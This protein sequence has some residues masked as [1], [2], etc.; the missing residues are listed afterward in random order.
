MTEP[1]RDRQPV[2][3]PWCGSE[4]EQETYVREYHYTCLN[5][6]AQSPLVMPY[7]YQSKAQAQEAAYAAAMKRNIP[8]NQ[9]AIKEDIP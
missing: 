8:E 2:I 1:I 7:E 3:C 4:M 9:P 6:F 5:C